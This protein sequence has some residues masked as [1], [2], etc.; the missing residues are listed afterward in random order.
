M[1]ACVATV[2]LCP[3]IV[4]P[5]IILSYASSENRKFSSSWDLCIL[6]GAMSVLNGKIHFHCENVCNISVKTLGFHSIVY[7]MH[8]TA[9]TFLQ[10]ILEII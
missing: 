2:D 10:T 5:T 4:A 7:R 3:L 1:I 8:C 6:Y 9:W